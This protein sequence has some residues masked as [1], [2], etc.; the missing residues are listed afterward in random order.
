MVSN[1][2]LVLILVGRQCSDSMGSFSFSR[3]I[4]N[5]LETYE[6]HW[7]FSAAAC[8]EH[9]IAVSETH[10]LQEKQNQNVLGYLTTGIFLMSRCGLG[11]VRRASFLAFSSSITT[12]TP[13]TNKNW[14]LVVVV[15]LAQVLLLEKGHF[16]GKKKE[17]QSMNFTETGGNLMVVIG[18]FREKHHFEKSRRW[19]FGLNLDGGFAAAAAVRRR[20]RRRRRQMTRKK[21]KEKKKKERPKNNCCLG[22]FLFVRTS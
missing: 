5:H 10:N 19:E 1:G 9:Y 14:K 7:M 11:L 2:V 3:A 18:Y 12:F 21:Q 4:C 22:L 16:C 17:V 13:T 15:G 8:K 6:K 20:R